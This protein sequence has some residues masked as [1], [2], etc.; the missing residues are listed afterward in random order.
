MPVSLVSS[1]YNYMSNKLKWPLI[2]GSFFTGFF[3]TSTTTSVVGSFFSSIGYFSYFF[4]VVLVPPSSSLVYPTFCLIFSSYPV[5]PVGL[6]F[7]FGGSFL[8]LPCFASSLNGSYSRRISEMIY[9]HFCYSL[10]Y[11]TSLI[12]S[13][14]SSSHRRFTDV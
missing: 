11:P 14:L 4:A 13:N 3:T 2:A 10:G 7:R 12:T 9:K 1:F 5:C 8:N 6:N